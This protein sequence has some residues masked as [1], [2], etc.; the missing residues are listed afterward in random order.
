MSRYSKTTTRTDQKTTVTRR[1][2]KKAMRKA[3]LT[4]EEE[5]VMRMSYG[6]SEPGNTPLEF[7]GQQDEQLSTKLAM[8]EAAALDTMRPRAVAPMALE[9]QE[10]KSA[11]V[12]RLKK[13]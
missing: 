8:M 12:D 11:I 13:L 4:R 6:V 3:D 9:G 7:R 10:L 5:L 1:E 2:L